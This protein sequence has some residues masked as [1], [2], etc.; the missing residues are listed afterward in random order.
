M[1]DPVVD[2]SHWQDNVNFEAMAQA[3]VVGV[4]HKATE[5]SSYIDANYSG[6]KKSATEAGLLWGAYHFLR[7]GD[8]VQQAK[9]F[10]NTAGSIDIYAADHEDPEVSLNDLK[11]FLREVKRLTGT[12][13]IIYSGHVIKEQVGSHPDPELGQYA[14]WLA[15]YTTASSPSWPKQIWP[16]WWL[17]QYTDKGSCPGIS[18]NCDLNRYDGP[19]D[20]LIEEWTGEEDV[21]PEPGPEPSLVTITIKV[22]GNA[23]VKVVEEN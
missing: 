9:H 15:H 3:G 20:E 11:T 5:G 4:I 10:V 2:I 16:E 1:T 8:M 6:R 23:I 19:V 13:P 7:P 21:I 14:L 18:G 17:W 12:T 22:T